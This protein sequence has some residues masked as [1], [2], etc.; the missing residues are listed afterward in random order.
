MI[1]EAKKRKVYGWGRSTFSDSSVFE[2]TNVDE[3]HET[4][5][6]VRKDAGRIA[7]RSAGRSYGDN[8]TSPKTILITT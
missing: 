1:A 3:I 6:K 4:V 7:C 5:K 2:V 8:T